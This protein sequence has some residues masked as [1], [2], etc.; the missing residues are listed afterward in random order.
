MLEDQGVKQHPDDPVK[1]EIDLCSL[2]FFNM[3]WKPKGSQTG[4]A[5]ALQ[6]GTPKNTSNGTANRTIYKCKVTL[7]VRMKDTQ[8]RKLKGTP[9]SILIDAPNEQQ[10]DD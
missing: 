1:F 3:K 6:K 9:N 2:V 8:K 4:R 10:E 5:D 7:L